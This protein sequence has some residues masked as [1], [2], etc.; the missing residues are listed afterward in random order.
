MALPILMSQREE[1]TLYLW[2][3]DPSRSIIQS[4]GFI[5]IEHASGLEINNKPFRIKSVSNDA[6][7]QKVGIDLSQYFSASAL[8]KAVKT[9]GASISRV[10]GG[11]T[12]TP[13]PPPLN[14]D[15]ETPD[16]LMYGGIALIVAVVGY[17]IWK[18]A[19]K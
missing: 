6:G 7:L 19:I 11:T 8:T 5:I 12:T 9:E 2:V 14:T 18:Y 1:T 17:L 3:Q 13:P 15:S 10:S 4:P 16:Y